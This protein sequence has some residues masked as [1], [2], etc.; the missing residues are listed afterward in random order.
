MVDD[1]GTLLNPRLTEGQVQG[2][3]VQG[4]GQAMMENV[5]YDAESGQL[6]VGSLMDYTLPRASHLPGFE[7]HLEGVPTQANALGVKGSGQAGCIGAPQTIINAILDALAPLGI[8]HIQM[9]ATSETVW[10][11]IQRARD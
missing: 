11:A 6:L 10:R 5:H 9:P 1:Y 7:T 8:D 2:G 3:V 4:I